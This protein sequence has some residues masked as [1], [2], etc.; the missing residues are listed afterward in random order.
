MEKKRIRAI[1]RYN[2]RENREAFIREQENLLQ[3]TERENASIRKEIA[4]AK[5][6]VDRLSNQVKQIEQE[7]K[8]R[9]ASCENT[10][11]EDED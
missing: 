3:N 6:T 4:E 11:E 9:Q 10:S 7:V 2:R 1:D 5:S 8:H